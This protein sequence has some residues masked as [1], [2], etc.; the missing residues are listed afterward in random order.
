MIHTVYLDD[1]YVN[2]KGLLQEIQHQ[3]EGVRFGFPL[4][5]NIV[6]EEYVTS[7]EFR[8]RAMA[9]VNTFCKENGIL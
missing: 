4:S 9:K 6:H 8:T 2:I 3:K 1:K 7:K 5:S